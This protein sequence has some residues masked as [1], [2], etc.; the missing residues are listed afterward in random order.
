MLCILKHADL[1]LLELRQMYESYVYS[2][3]TYFQVSLPPW[4]AEEK[5]G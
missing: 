4:I 2:L 1:K 3:S 5:M